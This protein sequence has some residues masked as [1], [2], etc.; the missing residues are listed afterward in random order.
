MGGSGSSIPSPMIQSPLCLENLL[1]VA[2]GSWMVLAGIR[3]D[4]APQEMWAKVSF[5]GDRP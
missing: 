4:G 3:A 5:E 1:W 2:I